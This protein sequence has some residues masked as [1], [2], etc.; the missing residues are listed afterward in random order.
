MERAEE[1]LKAVQMYSD[2]EYAKSG[3]ADDDYEATCAEEE[4]FYDRII[5]ESMSEIRNRDAQCEVTTKLL[6]IKSSDHPY[7]YVFKSSLDG[8]Y[9]DGIYFPTINKFLS[10]VPSY[11]RQEAI[12]ELIDYIVIKK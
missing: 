9:L 10:L 4:R 12:K 7:I 3:T 2:R 5:D 6:R 1:I 8:I 11:L